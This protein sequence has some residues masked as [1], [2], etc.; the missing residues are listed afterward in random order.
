[1]NRLKLRFPGKRGEGVHKKGRDRLN[2]KHS[3][4][5]EAPAMVRGTN[6]RVVVVKSPDPRIFEEAIFI[7]R[8]DLFRRGDSADKVLAEAKKSANAYLKSVAAGRK[9]W[10]RIRGTLFAAAGAVAAGV[11]W[12]ALHFVGV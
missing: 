2:W 10:A 12:I 6:R 3:E 9:P 8:E 5:R 7:I 11:A 1:M 4:N